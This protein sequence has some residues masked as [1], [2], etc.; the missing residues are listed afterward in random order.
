MP[1]EQD[2]IDIGKQLEKLV[3]EEKSELEM[4]EDLLRRL[5]ELP[6]T[7][8]ILQKTRIGMSVNV[9]RKASKKEETQTL[10]KGLIKSWKKLLDGQAEK[11][12]VQRQAS[13]EKSNGSNESTTTTPQRVSPDPT[14]TTNNNTSSV[15]FPP[16]RGD[17][18]VRTSFIKMIKSSLVC[19]QR[20]GFDQAEKISSELEDAIFMEFKNTESKYRNRLKSRVLNLRDKKNPDL[21]ISFLDGHITPERLAKM[22][23]EEMASDQLKAEREK[24]LKEGI[25]DAQ[26]G[27]TGGTVSTMMKCGKCGKSKVMYN[28]LQTRSSDEPM[29]TFCFC[30]ECGHR[31]KFCWH[32]LFKVGSFDDVHKEKYSEQ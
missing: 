10:A 28:Q 29:T 18:E 3:A 17:V 9:V 19:E 11:Q 13:S 5:K 22:T 23:S 1:L 6:I 7:L 31:W 14:P 15:A 12:K 25:N 30:Q 2:V 24:F 32:C 26:I 21:L 8:D 20:P 27:Q 4:A 16:R